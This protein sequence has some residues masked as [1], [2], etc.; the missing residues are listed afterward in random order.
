MAMDLNL[1]TTHGIKVCP[2][3]YGVLLHTLQSNQLYGKCALLYTSLNISFSSMSYD[4]PFSDHKVVVVNMLILMPM[5]KQRPTCCSWNLQLGLAFHT[6]IQLLIMI[7]S[8]MPL[9]ASYL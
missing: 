1:I 8:E 2:M 7:I 5:M 6:P 3:G 9:Q 4:T